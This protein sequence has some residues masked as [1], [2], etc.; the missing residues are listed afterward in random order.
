MEGFISDITDRKNYEKG[1]Q[2]ALLQQEEAVKAGNVGLW[3]WDLKT[4]QIQ[5]S[6]VWKRQIGYE[7]HEIGDDFTE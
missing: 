7:E 3:D 5:Y 2:E 4:N 6:E 1:M